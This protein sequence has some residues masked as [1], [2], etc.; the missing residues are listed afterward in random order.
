MRKLALGLF[1]L[2]ILSLL[3]AGCAPRPTGGQTAAQASPGEIVVDL[4]ALVLDF[5]RDG[6]GSIGGIDLGELMGGDGVSLPPNALDGLADANV[7]H[8]QLDAHPAGMTLRVNGLPMLGSI[9]YD[10][11]RLEST[12]TMLNELSGSPMLAMLDDLIPVLSSLVPLL[13]NLG[14]GVI[15]RFPVPEG[16][17]EVPLETAMDSPAP[18]GVVTDFLA[19]V[20]QQP[21]ISLPIVIEPDGTWGT[22]ELEPA[23]LLAMMG[24]NSDLSLPADTVAMLASSGI[25]T[26]EIRTMAEGLSLAV[27]GYALPLLTWNQGEFQTLLSLVSKA[28]ME[29]LSGLL[30]LVEVILPLLQVTD[31]DITLQFPDMNAAAAG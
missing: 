1:A 18:M 4:P 5:D 17:D 24:G 9:A 21:R 23:A 12:M 27:N 30:G 3:L 15:A 6:S 29:E 20:Q 28:D 13:D 31:L 25:A 16:M 2:L 10:P 22:N 8:I 7:Q 19:N 11:E 26:V 14:V